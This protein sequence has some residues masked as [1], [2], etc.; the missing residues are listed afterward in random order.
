MSSINSANVSRA[1]NPE[2]KG[3]LKCPIC[4]EVKYKNL[5]SDYNRRDRFEYR[6]TYVQCLACSHVYLENPPSWD[7]LVQLYSSLDK[8]FTA[9]SGRSDPERIIEKVSSPV[10]FWRKYLKKFG[11]RSHSWPLDVVPRLSKRIL[12]VG[13]GDGERLLE[14]SRRGYDVWGVDVGAQSIELCRNIL[15]GGTFS[16]G[17]LPELKLPP[18]SFDFIRIDNALEHMPNPVA[19]VRESFRLLRPSGKLMIYV[20]YGR[21]LT[22]RV[23][24]GG[25]ISSWMPFHLQLFTRKSLKKMLE[26]C[27]FKNVNIYGYNPPTWIPMSI[28]QAF[29]DMENPDLSRY[30][31]W[32]GK[33]LL[34]IGWLFVCLGLPE[35]LMAIGE[36]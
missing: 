7:K 14:F 33:A 12:D 16:R 28:V 25:S 34:P 23:F 6:G 32:L 10:S 5:F 17:E 8:N 9:N 19:V 29:Y 21:S 20:P 30:P 24:K 1:K 3:P 15:P 31:K 26:D 36:K 18:E 35:E 22:V 11:F 13:C 2:H 27:G 4:P